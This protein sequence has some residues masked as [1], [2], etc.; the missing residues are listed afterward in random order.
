MFV[1]F[2][3]V[4]FSAVLVLALVLVFLLIYV[5]TKSSFFLQLMKWADAMLIFPLDANTMAKLANGISDNLLV[6]FQANTIF[7]GVITSIV[8]VMYS[9][10]H[11]T[12]KMERFAKIVDGI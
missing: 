8:T 5:K 7:L 9:E 2:L 10:P 4:F 1:I 6:S 3:R 11:Q 12:S